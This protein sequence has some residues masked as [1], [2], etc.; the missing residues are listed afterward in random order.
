MVLSVALWGLLGVFHNLT[1]WGGT[2]GA[3]AATTS[4]DTFEGGPGHWQATSNSTVI[5]AGAFFIVFFKSIVALTCFGGAW[6]MWKARSGDAT[7]FA[8]AKTLALAG[9][10]AALFMLFTGWIVIAETWFELWRSDVLREAALDSAFRY[11]GLIGVI[12]LFVG[13]RDD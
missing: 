8:A 13:M 5:F 11:C 2:M 10:G 12:A 3:V 9:C 1:D 6:R 4:M 7:T